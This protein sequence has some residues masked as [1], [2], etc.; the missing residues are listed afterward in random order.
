MGCVIDE[1]RV[2]GIDWGKLRVYTGGLLRH[3]LD[4]LIEACDYLKYT[5]EYEELIG[6]NY[7]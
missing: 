5:W 3:E 2:A 1:V 6:S 7:V 4:A